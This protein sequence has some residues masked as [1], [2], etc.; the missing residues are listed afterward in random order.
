MW[1]SCCVTLNAARRGAIAPTTTGGHFDATNGGLIKN[2]NLFDVDLQASQKMS[3]P[4]TFTNNGGSLLVEPQAGSTVSIFS[5][6]TSSGSAS[7]TLA[8]GTLY[9]NQDVTID[10]GQTVYASGGNLTL[11]GALTV[12]QYGSIFVEESGTITTT[13]LTNSGTIDM[14]DD[15]K[16]V[17]T[18]NGN[19]VQTGSGVLMID[20]ICNP[21]AADVLSISGTAAL[22]GKLIVNVVN[23]FKGTVTLT[24]LTA[25]QGVSGRWANDNDLGG[26]TAGYDANDATLTYGP[27]RG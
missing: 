24:I 2:N 20:F 1:D 18:I 23:P 16:E 14:Q 10:A 7:I 15:A 5:T 8:A 4:G 13:T 26:L 9:I 6:Y 27:V 3:G 17:L 22:D 19:F 12:A 11:S 21:A 25:A